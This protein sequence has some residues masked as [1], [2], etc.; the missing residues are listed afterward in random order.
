M[1]RF[2]RFGF[3]AV[4]ACGS[5]A[6][7]TIAVTIGGENDTITRNPAVDTFI[8]EAVDRA[9]NRQ[10]LMDAAAKWVSGETL[11]I[12][13]LSQ[14]TVASIQ[15]TGSDSNGN[16]I[17]WGAVP[18]AELGA[19][20]GLTIPLFVQRKGDTARMPETIDAGT[21]PLLAATTRSVYAAGSDTNLLGY[22]MLFLGPLPACATPTTT[23]SFALVIS[24]TAN[25]DGEQAMAW[26][27]G[28][29]AASVYGIGECAGD[30]GGSNISLGDGGIAWSDFAGGRTVM[31]NSGT[32]YIVGPSRTSGALTGVIFKIVPDTEASTL[33]DAIISSISITPRRGAATA[34]SNGNGLFVYGGS[35]AG[36]D[37]GQVVSSDGGIRSIAAPTDAGADTREGLAAIA[38]DDNRMLVAGDDQT[39]IIVDLSCSQCALKTFGQSTGVKL[40]SP[41]LFPLPN[42]AFLLVGDDSTGTTRLFRLSDTDAGAQEKMLKTH[43]NRARAIQFE[44]GQIVII[45]G[46]SATPESYVD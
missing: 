1:R 12:T 9:G 39:P 15:L 25:T 31:D 28:D 8:V 14:T 42:G 40:T 30:Y 35:S 23:K 36:S 5:T 32:A 33:V 45:G 13:D 37:V 41:S 46:G 21:A 26:R 17:V 34:W 38:I 22:D 2:F 20:D 43:R 16:A 7:A 29:D 27:I 24:P 19:F 10:S 44:T 11:D 6:T 18:F 3:L 4:L